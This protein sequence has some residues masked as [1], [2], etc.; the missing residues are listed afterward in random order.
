MFYKQIDTNQQLNSDHACFDNEIALLKDNILKNYGIDMKVNIRYSRKFTM[1]TMLDKEQ[2][3]PGDWQT[4]FQFRTCGVNNNGIFLKFIRLPKA[5]QRLG[6]GSYC[7]HW[8][9]DWAQRFGYKYIVFSS[10]GTAQGFWYKMGYHC[11]EDPD[12]INE[13]NPAVLK[14]QKTSRI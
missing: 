2:P 1:V 5:K 4:E 6:L 3:L 10:K 13:L 14:R 9:E 12:F 7:V 11:S 8:L